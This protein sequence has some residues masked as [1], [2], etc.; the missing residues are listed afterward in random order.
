[1]S[2]QYVIAFKY[3]EDRDIDDIG[4]AVC[5]DLKEVKEALEAELEFMKED[6]ECADEEEKEE[7]EGGIAEEM[8]AIETVLVELEEKEDGYTTASIGGTQQLIR[9]VVK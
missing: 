6:L 4:L 3:E 7:L 1:M 8:E 9:K 2:T 5:A